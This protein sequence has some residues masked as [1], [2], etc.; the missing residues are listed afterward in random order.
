MNTGDV[1]VG[2]DRQARDH[3]PGYPAGDSVPVWLWMMAVRMD[4]RSI[5]RTVMERYVPEIAGLPPGDELEI[6][7]RGCAFV[8]YLRA[9]RDPGLQDADP[10]EWRAVAA[11]RMGLALAFPQA[12]PHTE[13]SERSASDVD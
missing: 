2:P 4:L 7:S 10:A 1:P 13:K 5:I 3:R 8:T 11:G 6:L 12:A 9:L